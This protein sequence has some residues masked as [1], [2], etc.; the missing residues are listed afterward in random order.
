MKILILLGIIYIGYFLNDAYS[1]RKIEKYEKNNPEHEIEIKKDV[2]IKTRK[3]W[4]SEEYLKSNHWQG[5][6]KI[7]L[8]RADYK[9]QVCGKRN[10]KLNVHHN[11]YENI[12]HEY[13]TDLCVLCVDCRKIFH[14]KHNN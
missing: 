3:Q 1:K 13:L 5:I 9:C 2:T 10:T 8:K 11:T 7:A 4:Y 6:R 12:G 14:K